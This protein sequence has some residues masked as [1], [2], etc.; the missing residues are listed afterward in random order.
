MR[1]FDQGVKRLWWEGITYPWP[2]VAEA[3]FSACLPQF[4]GPKNLEKVARDYA[5]PASMGPPKFGCV[6]WGQ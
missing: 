6:S 1:E 4:G 2:G 5:L 3:G